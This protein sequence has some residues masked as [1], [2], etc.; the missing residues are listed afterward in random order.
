MEDEAGL[1]ILRDATTAA[2]TPTEQSIVWYRIEEALESDTAPRAL[3]DAFQSDF[4]RVLSGSVDTQNPNALRAAVLWAGMDP[5]RADLLLPLEAQIESTEIPVQ[6]RWTQAVAEIALRTHDTACLAAL[7][8]QVARPEFLSHAFEHRDHT[9]AAVVKALVLHGT[10]ANFDVLSKYATE[11]SD[12][13]AKLL[14]ENASSEQLAARPAL[15][16][17]ILMTIDT[18]R[19]GSPSFARA[20]A[21]QRLH[22]LRPLEDVLAKYGSSA[23]YYQREDADNALRNGEYGAKT[24]AERSAKLLD[25]LRTLDAGE[26]IPARNAT[27]V[28]HDW[29]TARMISADALAAAMRSALLAPGTKLSLLFDVLAARDAWTSEEIADAVRVMGDSV[30]GTR[31]ERRFWTMVI[32]YLARDPSSWAWALELVHARLEHSPTAEE[33]LRAPLDELAAAL[34]P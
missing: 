19:K 10:P 1:S 6:G 7:A 3:G 32:A 9:K 13:V 12:V 30:F 18:T 14:L 33:A 20:I 11:G 2:T 24:E 26:K 5:G 27:R 29:V 16:D 31:L 23:D 22:E 17:G 8:R 28:L 15:I 25:I 4:V 34:A 21:L